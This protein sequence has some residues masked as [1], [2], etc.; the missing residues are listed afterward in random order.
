MERNA[1]LASHLAIALSRA[2]T[3]TSV[4]KQPIPPETKQKKK[5]GIL[6]SSPTYSIFSVGR[7]E[8]KSGV[9]CVLLD[10]MQDML[11]DESTYIL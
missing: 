1:C 3:P 6:T 5:K 9:E 4:S 10:M 8:V 11:R 2:S 7:K